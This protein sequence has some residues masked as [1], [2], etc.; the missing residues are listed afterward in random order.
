MGHRAFNPDQP[1]A[2]IDDFLANGFT[3]VRNAFSPAYIRQLYDSFVRSY[4]RYC[5]DKNFE[6]A[7]PVGHRRTM[8]T[9]EMKGA[10]NSPRLYANQR[11]LPLIAA[12]LG[13]AILGE[14][15]G[16]I[17]LPGA[18]EQ[19][20]HRD[21]YWLFDENDR[22]NHLMPP[23]AITVIVPLVPVTALNGATRMYAGSH[24]VN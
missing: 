10:F 19:H 23:Y 6:D 15:G 4:G 9:V 11:V 14:L 24:R 1:K 7:L 18:E 16:V 13:D 17:A 12:L 22:I 3:V 5:D 2:D 20:I 21:H 8:I